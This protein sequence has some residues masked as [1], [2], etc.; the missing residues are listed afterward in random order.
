[1]QELLKDHQ[2]WGSSFVVEP[3]SSSS[4]MRDGQPSSAGAMA[5]L[6]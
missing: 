6:C 1:M 3:P 2:E 5:E 4:A